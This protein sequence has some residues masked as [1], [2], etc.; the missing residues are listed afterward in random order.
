[1]EQAPLHLQAAQP[2]QVA[3]AVVVAEPARELAAQVQQ[4]APAS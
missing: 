4:A 3:A 2:T 1:M